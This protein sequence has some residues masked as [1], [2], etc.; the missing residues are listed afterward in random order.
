MAASYS[1]RSDRGWWR[2]QRNREW[3]ALKKCLPEFR[4][5][6]KL[7]DLGCGSGFYL[8]KLRQ[9]GYRRLIGVDRSG[10]MLKE[11][12]AVD[13]PVLHADIEEVVDLDQV[14]IALCA[15]AL[16][17]CGQPDKVFARVSDMLKSGA[18]FLLLF[19]RA[20]PAGYLY[21]K[22]HRYHDVDVNLFSFEELSQLGL[23]NGMKAEK[24]QSVWPF[25]GIIRFRKAA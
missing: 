9:M 21:K 14:D 10:S 19:P 5:D 24:V 6:D 8:K 1:S 13:I 16:E 2:V 17:F 15:G 20:V 25:T 23:R 18:V 22:F 4:T 7:V 11:V 3:H 12:I